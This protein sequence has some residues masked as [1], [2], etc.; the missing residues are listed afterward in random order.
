MTREEI[1]E[2]A[3]AYV[4]QAC[5]EQ[6]LPRYVEDATTIASV[7]RLLRA[8]G[9]AHPRRVERLPSGHGVRRD[10]D[11]LDQRPA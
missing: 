7:V 6:G 5:A 2:A 1:R 11:G 9:H 3:R 10:L 8:E 4:E